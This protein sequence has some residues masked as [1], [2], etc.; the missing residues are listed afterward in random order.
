M[1]SLIHWDGPDPFRE[2]EEL[3]ARWGRL[4]GRSPGRDT[5]E[6]MPNWM[7]T[8]DIAEDDK[9]Y[10][11]KAELPEVDKKDVHVT[12]ADGVLTIA[13][14]RN[15]EEQEK[16][17]RFHRVERSYGAFSRSFA[18]PPNAAEDKVTAEFKNGVL[19][20]RVS[21]TQKP[22]PKAIEVKVA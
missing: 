5:R 8:V 18:M 14:Q 17:K 4:L 15:Q 16:N 9:E 19:L 20:V 1:R 3:S 22:Q 21:K 6:G 7:P 13:G 12:M 10:L 2:L 11:I